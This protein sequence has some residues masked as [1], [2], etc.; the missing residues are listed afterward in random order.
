[1]SYETKWV[2]SEYKRKI[3]YCGDKK[4]STDAYDAIIFEDFR[5]AQ[6]HGTLYTNRKFEVVKISISFDIQDRLVEAYDRAMR[7]IT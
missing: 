2:I 6:H 5:S 1:M 3:Y 7:G 4:W